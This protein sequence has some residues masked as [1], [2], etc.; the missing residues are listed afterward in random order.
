MILLNNRHND[1]R[2]FFRKINYLLIGQVYRTQIKESPNCFR[3]IFLINLFHIYDDA[4]EA[5][6]GTLYGSA[7]RTWQFTPTK[8]NDLEYLDKYTR[9]NTTFLL[10]QLSC[11]FHE[12]IVLISEKNDIDYL[13]KKSKQ[14][15]S[16]A[17]E[18]MKE[19]THK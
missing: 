14:N 8:S 7:F 13:L 11:L 18:L 1:S 10:W 15:Q 3:W 2:F 12:A 9:K 16:D 6:H 19:A 5:L 17:T 4:S